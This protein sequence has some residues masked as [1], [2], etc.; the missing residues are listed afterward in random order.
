MLASC[1]A[2]F[3]NNIY[4]TIMRKKADIEVLSQIVP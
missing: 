1:H 2:C 4:K 3:S